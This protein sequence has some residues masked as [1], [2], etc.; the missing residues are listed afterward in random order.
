MED[1]NRLNKMALPEQD[2][3]P[4]CTHELHEV[5]CILHR[6]S[7]LFIIENSTPNAMKLNLKSWVFSQESILTLGNIR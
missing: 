1:Q 4:H 7:V 3:F 5:Q 2:D 6:P